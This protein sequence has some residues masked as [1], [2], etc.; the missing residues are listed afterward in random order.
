MPYTFIKESD[1]KTVKRILAASFL[2]ALSGSA[3]A[4]TTAAGVAPVPAAPVPPAPPAIAPVP[5]AP[6]TLP[7]PI[8]APA[9]VPAPPAPAVVPT[10]PAPPAPVNAGTSGGDS[11]DKD[12]HHGKK[13]ERDDDA[14]SIHVSA[15]LSGNVLT[16]TKIS[17]VRLK[18]GDELSGAGIPDGTK[19]IGFGTGSGGVG[20]YTV[21]IEK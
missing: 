9:V 21:S 8:A 2:V 13:S 16:V 15:T 7:T 10:P 11:H 3:L 12:R 19:I 4:A 6:P 17:G 1:M 20:T 18:I 5:P 14:E